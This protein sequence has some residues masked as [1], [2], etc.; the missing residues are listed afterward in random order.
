MK[1]LA[2]N[3][4]MYSKGIYCIRNIVN[5]KRYIGKTEVNFNRRKNRHLCEL[6]SNKH[7]NNH[8]QNSYN[9]YG[10]DNF[11]FELIKSLDEIDDFA[12]YES[13]YCNIYNSFDKDY[14]YNIRSI[15]KNVTKSIRH[16]ENA[17]RKKLER[18]NTIE[19]SSTKERGLKKS[20]IQY[21]LNGNIIA[22]YDSGLEFNKETLGCEKYISKVLSKRSLLY[23]NTIVLFGNDKLSKKDLIDANNIYNSRLGKTVYLFNQFGKLIHEFTNVNECSKLLNISN[24]RNCIT[25]NVARVDIFYL[26]YNPNEYRDIKKSLGNDYYILQ[27]YNKNNEL[28]QEYFNLSSF[29]KMEGLDSSYRKSVSR[30]LRG[31]RKTFDNYIWKLKI[32]TE[33]NILNYLTQ[34]LESNLMKVR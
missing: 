11:V 30:C 9:K 18:V 23:K 24:P 25:N 28:I 5:N 4:D 20:I 8:L 31:E 34:T 21:D 32:Q 17:R 26:S 22:K 19:G 10:K 1:I 12:Y 3:L 2:N 29:I 27:K 13:H 6:I 7:P 33:E 15:E 14:G 16:S